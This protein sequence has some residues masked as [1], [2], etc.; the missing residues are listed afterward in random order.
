MAPAPVLAYVVA[1]VVAHLAV[2]NHGPHFHRL[3]DGGDFRAD[4]N[5]VR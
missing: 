1:H 3:V 4:R 2:P 5:A